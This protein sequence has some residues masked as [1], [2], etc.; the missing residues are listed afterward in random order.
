VNPRFE[1]F[2]NTLLSDK[3]GV[4][5]SA[6]YY[7]RKFERIRVRGESSPEE[8]DT[9]GDGNDDA[10]IQDRLRPRLNR[11]R[12]T[13]YTLAGTIQYK[14]SDNF[15]AYFDATYGESDGYDPRYDADIRYRTSHVKGSAATKNETGFLTTVPVTDFRNLG[16]GGFNNDTNDKLMSLAAGFDWNVS[17]KANLKFEVAKSFNKKINDDIPGFG[18]SVR[19]N[20]AFDPTPLDSEDVIANI[21]FNGDSESGVVIQDVAGIPSFG[22]LDNYVFGTSIGSNGTL[23]KTRAEE[24]SAKIDFEHEFGKEFAKSI[25]IGAKYTNRTE[26]ENNIRRR[27]NDRSV[28]DNIKDYAV[29]ITEYD[30]KNII[31]GFRYYGVDVRAFSKDIF[32]NPDNYTATSDG[33]DDEMFAERNIFSAYGMLNFENRRGGLKFKGNIGMRVVN[34]NTTTQG[35]AAFGGARRL[36]FTPDGGI[37]GFVRQTVD[38]NYTT[39]LPSLNFN[40]DFTDNFI[41]RLSVARVMRR[42]EIR[43]MTPYFE[44]GTEVDDLSGDIILNPDDTDGRAGNPDLDPFLAT[45]VD[46][47]FEYYIKGGGI[48]SAGLFYKDVQN[49]LTGARQVREVAAVDPSTNQP[50]DLLVNVDTFVNGGGASIKGVELS[51]QQSFDFLPESLQGLG[52][53]LN[54]TYTDSKEDKTGDPLEGTSENTFN[55]TL[56]FEKPMWG[57]RIAHNYRDAYRE[58][59]NF[60]FR[61]GL[62]LWDASAYV[63]IMDDKLKFTVNA[64][65]ITDKSFLSDT[66]TSELNRNYNASNFSDFELSGRQFLFGVIYS[67]F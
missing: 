9:N 7:D 48:F 47:S 20:D 25:K 60:E 17:E 13:T 46:L 57:A 22:N 62:G 31:P 6:S 41:G 64:V 27:P 15:N 34:T 18:G 32:S 49:F 19:I 5:V 54:Y 44:I 23:E 8:L 21:I 58:G 38:K 66:L 50:V 14:A 2:Y 30:D 28:P 1:A 39:L 67:I 4:S 65:N 16:F 11:D 26:E 40:T 3:W 37:D 43:Q 36:E 35:Y 51:Y 10:F 29:M 59:G 45:Q 33:A 53:A 52:M 12:E 24:Y 61:K 55:G 42:P 56:Y 63:S